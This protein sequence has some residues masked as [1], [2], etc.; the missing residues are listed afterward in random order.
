M[1][2]LKGFSYPDFQPGP[3]GYLTAKEGIE[4]LK[5]NLKTM[6]MTSK[7]E[8]VNM[9]DYGSD[10]EKRIFDPNTSQLHDQMKEDIIQTIEKWDASCVVLDVTVSTPT[11]SDVGTS[12]DPDHIVAMQITFSPKD[13]LSVTDVLSIVFPKN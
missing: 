3:K 9:P 2:T 10:L 8:R 13:D 1:T 6:I 7:G 12:D 5:A 4:V 11:A